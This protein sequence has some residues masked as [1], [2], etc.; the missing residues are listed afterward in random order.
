MNTRTKKRWRTHIAI[1]VLSS[2]II[3]LLYFSLPQI[4]R[5]FSFDSNNLSHADDIIFRLSLS[6]GYVAL[7]LLLFTLLISALNL[8]KNKKLLPIQYDMRRDVGIWAGVL[9]IFHSFVG[10]FVHFRDRANSFLYYFI[11]PPETKAAIPFRFDLFGLANYTGLFGVLLLGLLLAISNDFALRKLGANRWKNLQRLNYLFFALVLAHSIIY[12]A[13]EKRPFPL[14]ACSLLLFGLTVAFQFF[15]ILKHRSLRDSKNEYG[16]KT[17][18]Q[19][20]I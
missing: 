3:A 1:A 13:I 16:R 2:L 15:G 6:L 9:G 17:L 4:Y 12:A 11:F 18:H 14:L 20:K 7:L 10:L 8:L 19:D 5:L